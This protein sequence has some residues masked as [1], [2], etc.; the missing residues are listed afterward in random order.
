[1]RMLGSVFLVEHNLK[2]GGLFFRDVL[3]MTLL[4]AAKFGMQVAQRGLF[5]S[6]TV[7]TRR[8]I[9]VD[10][11]GVLVANRICCFAYLTEDCLTSLANGSARF[12]GAMVEEASGTGRESANFDC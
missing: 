3:V 5:G 1:M 8:P 6:D 11:A 9:G 7:L 10:N 12:F 4:A 2:S